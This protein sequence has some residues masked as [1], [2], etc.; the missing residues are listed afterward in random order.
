VSCSPYSVP[1]ANLTIAQVNIERGL[2]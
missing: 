1:I 2:A